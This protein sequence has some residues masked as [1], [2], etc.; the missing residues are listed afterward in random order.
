MNISV[1]FI[2]NWV[3]AVASY[4]GVGLG[5]V[6]TYL[7]KNDKRT[8]E[9]SQGFLLRTF[10]ALNLESVIDPKLTPNTSDIGEATLAALGAKY[11]NFQRTPEEV[12]CSMT[13]VEAKDFDGLYVMFDPTVVS[14]VDQVAAS[15]AQVLKKLYVVLATKCGEDV[16]I[17]S[18]LFSQYMIC[19]TSR[20]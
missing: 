13:F 8:W 20:T 6:D 11:V 16:A 15:K 9:D 14:S 3:S 2:P 5:E 17:K 12:F 10:A 19:C 18:R 1:K 4:H 7:T